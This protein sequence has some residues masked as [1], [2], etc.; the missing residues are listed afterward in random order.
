[1]NKETLKVNREKWSALQEKAKQHMVKDQGLSDALCGLAVNYYG[2]NAF[3]NV[4]QRLTR[5]YGKDPNQI[6]TIDEFWAQDLKEAVIF[7]VGE[8][9]Q[10]DM[11]EM[12]KIRLD[13]QFSQS[14][15][16][17]SYR[18]RD[19]GY[20]AVNLIQS[21]CSWI[22]WTFYETSVRD[23]LFYQH[24]WIRGYE[25]YLALEIRKG[26]QE[27]IDLLKEAMYGD[28]QEILLSR[29]MIL[30]VI[31]SGHEELLNLLLKLL[32]A[33]RLQE[34]L[35][36]QILESADAGSTETLIKILK[37]CID[38]DMFRYS[39]ATRAFD[40]WT[41][42]GYGDAKPAV[43]KKCAAFAYECLTDAGIR[44]KYL[45][46]DNN[47]E[48]YFALW[49]MGCYDIGQTDTMARKLLDDE[50]KYR[51]ML[52]WLF[53]SRTDNAGYRMSMASRY[54]DERDE[55]ILAWIVSNLSVTSELMNSYT[56]RR[57]NFECRPVEN[58]TLPSDAGKRQELFYELKRTAEFIGNKNRTFT[59]NPFAFT[60][61]TLENTRVLGCMMSL[62]GYDM[63]AQ[64]IDELA[65]IRPDMNTEQRKAFYVN[66]LEPEKNS[67]HRAYL[68]AALED[69]SIHV[70]ELA[71][72][73]LSKCSLLD[74]DMEALAGSLRSKSSSLRKGVLSIFQAQSP[75]KLNPVIG[76]MLESGEEYQIQ[77]GIELLLSFKNEYPEMQQAQRERLAVLQEAGLST[78]T[79]ILLE[80]L[81]DQNELPEEAYTEENG[82]G[83]YDP[84]VVATQVRCEEAPKQKQ[85][86]IGRLLGKKDGK[87][88][89]FSEKEIKAF[90]PA[91]KEFEDLLER[92]NSV[93]ERHADYEYEVILWDGSR[94]KVLF[95]DANCS[96][97]LVPAKFGRFHYPAER[98]NM[99][100]EMI[101]FYDEFIRAAGVYAADI[102]KMLG[103]CYVI[104]RWQGDN[105]YGLSYLP[106]FEQFLNR[107]LSVNYNG[108]GYEKY[109]RRYW[110]I[111]DMLKLLPQLFDSHECFILASKF[112]RSM[113][114]ILGKENLGKSYVTK[115]DSRV[116]Y[117]H[118]YNKYPVNHKMIMFWRQMMRVSAKRPEDFAEWFMVE[119]DLV[120]RLSDSVVMAG[121]DMGD[122]FRAADIQLVPRDVLA[123]RLLL[124]GNAA[125]S[126]RMLTNPNRWQQGRNIYETYPWAGEFVHKLVLRIVEVEEKRGELPTSLTSV[127]RA[128]ERFEGAEYFCNLLAALGKENFFHG[129][130]YSSDTTKKAVLSRLLKRCYP[131]KDDTPDKLRMYLAKTDIK[132]KRLAEAIMYAPQWAGFAEEILQWPGLKCGVWF[133]HAHINETFSAEKE[134]EAAIY[135]P[136][137][138]QQFNDG[139][140]D[141][142]W[143]FEAYDQL[144]EKRFMILYKSA[145]YI[146]TGSNQHRRSQLY[147]D[148][149]LGRLDAEVL[150][151]EIIAKRNQ[152]KMRCYPLIPIPEGHHDEALRRYEFIQKFL[153]ES[154]QFGSQR[155]ESEKKA[156]NTAL[157]NLAITTGF[158]DVNRMTW[159]LESEKMEEIRPLM[160][161]QTIDSVCIWLEIDADGMAGL[162]IEKNGKRQKTLPKALNKNESVL[163]IKE[164]VKEL[165]EQRRRAK[166]SL[167]RA[168]VESTEF[169]IGEL[170]R[171][172]SNPVLAPMLFALVWTDGMVNGL[173][174]MEDDRLILRDIKGEKALLPDDS[175]LRLSHPYD[176]MKAGEW[177]A[178]MHSFYERRLVQ[179]FK[180]VFREYYPITEDERQEKTI[181]RRYA[182]HQVQPQKTV[183]LL[184]S[185]GWTVDYEEGLQKVYYK[186]NL[187]VRMY[188]LADWFSPA[189]I[190]AP[191]LETIR[192][193]D[194]KNEDIVDLEAIPPILFSEAMRDMDLVVS[195]AHVGGVD[196]EASHSTV[197]MRTAIA[198]ELVKLLKITNVEFVGSHA[199]IHGSLANY[200]VHMGSG[201]VHGEGTG[202]IAI[203]PVHSQARGRIF[204]PF[205]D[206]DPKTAEIMSK[207]IMLS[208]DKKIK[209]PGILN[210][211]TGL[212]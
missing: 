185:R 71:V 143:F 212:Y 38:E 139:A 172:S 93:F 2:G 6:E 152:E 102:K 51:R 8:E 52:G 161:P 3:Q 64:L 69:R 149:V 136:I 27:I 175:K 162:A 34:G 11:E 109:K 137:T 164:T 56:Y 151:A 21:I 23:M 25:M 160:E 22:Y 31:I 184:K 18:T 145:K 173:L 28:N 53:V 80:Q 20:H 135:S 154:K 4:W 7:L 129:Y 156:C 117:Y 62:A 133:F 187:I 134:T 101:P 119:Y 207:I 182:G 60:S 200:S 59:G 193:F 174:E 124:G 54:I 189:D 115:K 127:A 142:N 43:V 155:R 201:V 209:D 98:E 81:Q 148:A 13:C 167:E 121:P 50:K 157:E 42:L 144:G 153:K 180:Q 103:L 191:T 140:F 111:N 176:L 72:K 116:T 30:A 1:M 147:T 195:V 192:F 66:F 33:A 204:L 65:G 150:K 118:D 77:A 131:A 194:R 197:E 170:E 208:E 177:P 188:A 196:P 198:A 61:I 199:K 206:E 90:L 179:P 96:S 95:G 210:Q 99:K 97:L 105:M 47:L 83:L 19:V 41:G 12:T 100:P 122:Y 203:L 26:N 49:S 40:T 78:Q 163:T 128:I 36:Q 169:Y 159:Y 55:E 16:R 126:I 120:R 57:E 10:A 171:I 178:F 5:V 104:Y 92:M 110:Q 37:V 68:R 48:A 183:A 146:T 82:F 46:S 94:S 125:S 190:E 211:I 58:S 24:E 123:E 35:R 85:G 74:E 168:M 166:E 88:E 89:L 15:W 112:Y 186:E 106:W 165:K 76:R 67:R 44:A 9:R 205:A 87:A 158:M 45:D 73:R 114:E 202:M 132:E 138:P 91:R 17:R 75:A 84:Q 141:K 32:V 130:D 39:S 14:M 63:D 113:V 79:M 70:K 86:F 29:T 108:V 107:G 181:S